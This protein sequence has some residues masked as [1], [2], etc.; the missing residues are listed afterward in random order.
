M[1]SR[2]FHLA[3]SVTGLI[4]AQMCGVGHAEEIVFN[5]SSGAVFVDGVSVTSINGVDFEQ[6][7]VQQGT[8]GGVRQFRFSGDLIFDSNDK[9]S[10]AGFLPLSF[11]AGND[12]LVDANAL[13]DFDAS[14]STG[15]L[16]G[17]NGGIPFAGAIGGNG[18]NGANSGGVRGLRGSG[19]AQR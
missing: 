6:S 14:G 18:G 1:K 16:G 17:G 7:V 12:I 4:I 15:D 8:D 3:L 13:F 2:R 9:V 10:A 5:T 11:Y 19:G